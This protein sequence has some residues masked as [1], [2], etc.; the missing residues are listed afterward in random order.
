MRTSN[1][2]EQPTPIIKFRKLFAPREIRSGVAEC[3]KEGGYA[4]AWLRIV[5]RCY[6]L[7]TLVIIIY[8]IFYNFTF[9]SLIS[10]QHFIGRPSPMTLN[11]IFNSFH[12]FHHFSAFFGIVTIIL[13]N[14]RLVDA[15]LVMKLGFLIALT[16]N[17]LYFK[18]ITS[19]NKVD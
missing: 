12:H 4:G 15:I 9:L 7:Y 6:V 3:S 13:N 2:S 1:Q 11:P 16:T 17:F 14:F 19:D 8:F 10:F 5:R 18:A